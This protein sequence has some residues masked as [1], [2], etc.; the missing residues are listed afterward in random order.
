MLQ[1]SANEPHITQNT[2]NMRLL[3]LHGN[4]G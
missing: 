4:T 2:F 3:T 1:K